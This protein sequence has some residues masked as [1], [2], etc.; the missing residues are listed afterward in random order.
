MMLRFYHTIIIHSHASRTLLKIIWA[1]HRD[2]N[3]YQ[4]I[5]GSGVLK[6]IK[7][8]GILILFY[9][10]FPLNLWYY[11]YVQK[12]LRHQ[13]LLRIFI[14]FRIDIW[15]FYLFNMP[16]VFLFTK[17]LFMCVPLSD[18]NKKI[19]NESNFS[20]NI[21]T[22]KC[23]TYCNCICLDVASCLLCTISHI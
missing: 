14:Y 15:T 20:D 12:T 23:F 18:L 13:S 2:R 10:F 5:K 22:S 4:H 7:H 11:F 21:W 8:P 3:F 9:K 1:L 16:G 6:C 19:G 17:F